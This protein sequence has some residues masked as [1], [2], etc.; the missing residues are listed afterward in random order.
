MDNAY[1]LYLP[2]FALI[3]NTNW[4]YSFDVFYFEMS[5][6]VKHKT[7]NNNHFTIMDNDGTSAQSC[8]TV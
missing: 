5:V 3:R 6:G 1:T 7:N 8:I 2:L 4:H